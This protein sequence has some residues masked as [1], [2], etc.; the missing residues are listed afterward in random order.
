MRPHVLHL[1]ASCYHSPVSHT[2]RGLTQTEL[3]IAACISKRD[4]CGPQDKSQTALDRFCLH[5]IKPR[6]RHARR[7][8]SAAFH[9]IHGL[10]TATA[11][12][13]KTLC[14]ECSNRIR[15]V[16]HHVSE[17]MPLSCL[18]GIVSRA[19]G[20]PAFLRG[21]AHEAGTPRTLAATANWTDEGK[22][23]AGLVGF[24]DSS[25][26]SSRADRST[27]HRSLSF[28]YLSSPRL[29][30]SRHVSHDAGATHRVTA[31]RRMPRRNIHSG[32]GA[33]AA[34]PEPV[35]EGVTF[36]TTAAAER[37][38]G[39]PACVAFVTGANRGIGLEVTRQLLEKTKGQC[40]CVTCCSRHCY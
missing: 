16:Y 18:T 9:R 7:S 8:G 10:W 24:G 11:V 29:P 26:T 5:D 33:A 6:S 34:A 15:F 25:S 13:R 32:T 39:D 19:S 21:F 2:P 35:G 37:R 17:D 4:S 23:R 40:T 36:K 38:N 22:V 12:H 14:T 1:H 31:S 20:L 27:A 30:S 3:I 28:V